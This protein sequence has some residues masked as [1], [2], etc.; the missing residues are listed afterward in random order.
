MPDYYTLYPDFS[1]KKKKDFHWKKQKITKFDWKL[2]FFVKSQWKEVFVVFLVRKK[3]KKLVE[4]IFNS[5]SRKRFCGVDSWKPWLPKKKKRKNLAHTRFYLV[6]FRFF[7][8]FIFF[9]FNLRSYWAWKASFLAKLAPLQ[10]AAIFKTQGRKKK[11]RLG[12]TEG[13]AAFLHVLELW[14]DT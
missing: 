7:V 14:I 6:L 1:S 8:F 11:A 13:I 10:I 12:N 5:F 9:Y 3:E 4:W 2:N